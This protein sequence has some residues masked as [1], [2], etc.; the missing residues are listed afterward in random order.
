MIFEKVL[1]TINKH[2]LIDDGDKV[3]LG[4]SG[5]PDSVCLLH[6]LYR[7]KEKMN[8]EVY[9]A[10]LNHQIRGIEAQ[11]DA[12]YI[13]QICE[14]L[15]ITSFVKSV[16]V[17]QYCKENG[18]SLEEGARK[19]RYEMF[20][21]IKEKTKS[22][23]IA[24]GH[25]LNDQ[26]ET[27]LMRIMRGTGLQGLK[28]IAYIRDNEIIRPILDIERSEIEQY[29][30][31]YELNPRIDKTNLESIYTRNK[32]RLELIPYMK[33][34]FNPNIIETIVR[35]TSSL[36]SD[37]DYIELE[38]NKMFKEVSI[39]KEDSVE[40]NLNKYATLH[41]AIKVRVLRSGIKHI[42]GDTNFVDQ[43]H[44][45][46]VMELECESKINKMLTLPR[47][48]FAYR[49]KNI[50]ILTTK[51]IVSEEIDFCYNIP[52]NGF[53]KVKELNLILETQTMN[54]DRY[55]SIKL[56]KTSKGFDFDKVKGGI[57]V[58]SR[59]QG[60]K[61]K[62][63]AGSKKI[64]DLFIDLKIPREDRC[65]VPVVTDDEGI[66]CVGDYKTS[67]DYKIDSETK[68]VLKVSFKKL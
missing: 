41:N 17:P 23:K 33:D 62:L 34:N 3:V 53:I 15:G 56:D 22:N 54:I 31:K 9:A 19:L 37:G 7:L 43:K 10:H 30:E 51:E 1:S 58:R 11:Q 46:D 8:I 25:N 45:D 13:S 29:C 2:N 55:K 42:L 65:K 18:L 12:L 14:D 16:N 52:S 38:A 26:A 32:I 66:L 21:E 61:V 24:I 27:V 20:E 4:L 59:R 57:V 67:E 35:M 47:G 5:G 40:I 39:L 50:I 48:I 63:A 44:I 49:R 68:E 36:K 60:D 6:I 28:G 64:K